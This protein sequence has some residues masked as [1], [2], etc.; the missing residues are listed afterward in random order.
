MRTIFNMRKLVWTVVMLGAMVTVTSCSDDDDLSVK[1]ANGKYEGVWQASA[2]SAYAYKIDAEVK[3]GT[4]TF[5]TALVESIIMVVEGKE[6]VSDLLESVEVASNEMAYAGEVDE[7]GEA[8]LMALG[9]GKL[10]FSY[11]YEAEDGEAGAREAGGETA[12]PEVV[13]V[14]VAVELEGGEEESVYAA[15]KLD[16]NINIKKVVVT[17]DE[18]V[19]FNRSMGDV[20]FSLNKKK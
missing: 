13:E 17:V 18:D 6:D 20:E 14:T 16:L 7:E 15:K 5:G 8:V 2:E 19:I 10:E 3:N 1:D 11:F 4:L 9:A 12:E